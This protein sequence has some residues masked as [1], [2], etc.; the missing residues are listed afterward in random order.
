M[1][2]KLYILL[3]V[4]NRKDI[5]IKFVKMLLNQTY[6]NYHLVLI[7]DGSSDGTV[8]YIKE[9]VTDLT[10][11]NGDGNLW[12]GGALHQGYLWAK[13]KIN[14]SLD[15]I[16]I[17][18]DDVLIETDFLATGLKILRENSFKTLVI[19]ENFKEEFQ[20]TL[21][22]SGVYINWKSLDFNLKVESGKANC[23]STRG[24]FLKFDDFLSIGGFFPKAL[25]HYLSDYEF[26][27]RAYKKG[28][29]IITNPSLK[30]FTSNN[31][32][33]NHFIAKST[34][35]NYVKNLFSIKYVGNPVYFTT[36]ILLACPFYLI[37]LNLLKVWY[38][39]IKGLVI[40][41]RN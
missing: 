6:K 17:I 22:D 19:A 4:H 10:I 24:L 8:E 32:T 38:G 12:W 39:V 18:N 26:S 36:F 2:Q 21:I 7:D 1:N 30:L 13:N 33:G 40:N 27:H 41:Q 20:D 35:K 37:P 9:Y 15:A 29:K 23:C 16:L 34:F 14:N 28:F 5:S 3:P 11:I 25:P 31:T